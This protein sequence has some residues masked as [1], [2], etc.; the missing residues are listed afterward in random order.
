MGGRVLRF[1]TAEDVVQDLHTR[2]LSQPPA[3]EYRGE[4]ELHAFLNKAAQ[5]HLANRHAHWLA[6]RRSPTG[7]LRLTLG[8][9]TRAG[10]EP[11]DAA[12]GPATFSERRDQL[13]CAYEALGAL[14]PR[15]ADLVRWAMED[16]DIAEVAQ[17]LSVS[18]E[19]AQ[20]ARLRALERFQK[21]FHLARRRRE[22]ARASEATPEQSS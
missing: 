14:L 3:F 5:R 2:L 10:L 13:R 7:L 19:A 18:Y 11:A 8:S 9:D 6:L 4:A 12:T 22:A 15:D 21:T 20:R 16:L 1:E 17:R